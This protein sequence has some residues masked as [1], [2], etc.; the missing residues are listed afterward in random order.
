M[1]YQVQTVYPYPASATPWTS[2]GSNPYKGLQAGFVVSHI[3]LTNNSSLYAMASGDKIE[4]TFNQPV[5]TSTGPSNGATATTGAAPRVCAIS[6]ASGHQIL[7]GAMGLHNASCTAGETATVGRLVDS[8]G[9]NRIGQTSRFNVTW[10]WSSCPV[11]N[12]CRKLTATLGTRLQPSAGTTSVTNGN[13]WTFTP[14]TTLKSATGSIAICDS[15]P[16]GGL[17][18]P[19]TTGNF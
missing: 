5:D 6:G 2:Q 10:A 19:R 8:A 3:E 13:P 12:Q 1:C 7:V 14:T 4:I 17:C 16:T 15:N 18:R 9:A 11:T